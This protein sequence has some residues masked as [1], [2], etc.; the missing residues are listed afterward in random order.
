MTRIP[1]SDERDPEDEED[2]VL[3][4]SAAVIFTLGLAG[5]LAFYN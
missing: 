3:L 1:P 2:V 5:V 4:L